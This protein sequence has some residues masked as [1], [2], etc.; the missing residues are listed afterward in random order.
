MH[1][2]LFGTEFWNPL[3]E[4]IKKVL[5]NEVSTITPED[6]QLYT[7]TDDMEE[8]LRLAK[9]APTKTQTTINE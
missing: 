7:I 9:A 2:I 6:R 5:V 3:D 8:V 1:V 4:Y